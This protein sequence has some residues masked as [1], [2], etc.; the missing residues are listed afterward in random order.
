MKILREKQSSS[1]T[2]ELLC[3]RY[4]FLYVLYF[5][6]IVKARCLIMHQWAEVYSPLQ[7]SALYIKGTVLRDFR[8]PLL[9][10]QQTLQYLRPPSEHAQNISL[11]TR[12]RKSLI[13]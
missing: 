6:V 5:V 11:T 7:S 8:P 3:V 2:L 13:V 12:N 9:F 1:C 10:G 4:T